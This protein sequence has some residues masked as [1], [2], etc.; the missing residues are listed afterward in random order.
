MGFIGSNWA[1]PTTTKTQQEAEKKKLKPLIVK[2]KFFI[3]YLQKMTS[4]MS[5]IEILHGFTLTYLISIFFSS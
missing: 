5:S 4:F 1:Y 3:E 2:S